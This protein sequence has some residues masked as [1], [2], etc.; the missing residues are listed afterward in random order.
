MTSDKETEIYSSKFK[1]LPVVNRTIRE[2]TKKE[3]QDEINSMEQMI[4]HCATGT[5]DL[6]YLD[7]LYYEAGSRGY[8]VVNN[9]KISLK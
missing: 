9:N 3:L 8:E 5:K 2:Y 6:I 7:K 1:K 4:E